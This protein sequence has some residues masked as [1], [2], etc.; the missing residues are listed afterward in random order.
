MTSNLSDILEKWAELYKPI[1]HNPT[2]GSKQ[3][4]YYPIKMISTESE[5]MRNQNTAASPCMAYSVLVDAEG[6]N[7][8]VIDYAHTIYFLHRGV[9]T[10]LAKSAKQDDELGQDVHLLMDEYVQD[11][12]AYLR[13]LKHTGKCP[14]TGQTYSKTTLD[15]LRGLNLDKAQ[16]G[17]IP[18]KYGN[19][20]IMGVHISQNIPRLVCI[21]TEKY[22]IPDASTTTT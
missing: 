9:A 10:S 15:A 18:T 2:K 22:N 21:R 14:I 4:A 13:Q 16:W 1:S 20:H 12:L 3:K 5:F 7:T 19:W 8:S 17:S 11:L 6:Q